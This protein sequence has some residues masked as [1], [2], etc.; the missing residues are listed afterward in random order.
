[1]GKKKLRDPEVAPE[2]NDAVSSQSQPDIFN[3]LFGHV[4][5]AASIFSDQNPF[6]RKPLPDQPQT[7]TPTSEPA[8]TSPGGSGGSG[9]KAKKP[10]REE[11]RVAA[12]PEDAVALDKRQKKRKRD[13]VE[14]EYEERKYGYVDGGD[15]EGDK[16]VGERVGAKRKTVDNPAEVL[17]AK[18]GFD[19]EVKLLRT[20]FV[21]NLPLSLKKKA[22]IKEF[23]RFGE[24]ESV[25]IRSV[26]I[27]DVSVF[28]SEL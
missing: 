24:V 18:E 9:G 2:S 12:E 3:A 6:K 10:K 7:L 1:M 17:V 13:E 27:A 22:L 28:G 14:R 15:E 26:P 5:D 20:V 16:R 19:D 8:P 11:L 25:R 23:A 4:N 21:G